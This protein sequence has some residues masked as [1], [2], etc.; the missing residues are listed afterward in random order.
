MGLFTDGEQSSE[1]LEWNGRSTQLVSELGFDSEVCV[2][3]FF[4]VE[5]KSYTESLNFFN[6][7]AKAL[8][9]MGRPC[10]GLD[11]RA[12]LPRAGSLP[13]LL[14]AMCVL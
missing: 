12:Q 14:R 9:V 2:P 11:G 13:R 3:L 7:Y 1:R 8:P 6:K 5:Y 4:L 10:S